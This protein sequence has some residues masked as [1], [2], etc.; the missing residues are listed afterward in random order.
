MSR[1]RRRR[2]RRSVAALAATLVVSTGAGGCTDDAATGPEPG[3]DVTAC[4]VEPDVPFVYLGRDG[5]PT[6]FSFELLRAIVRLRRGTLRLDRVSASRVEFRL[7]DGRCDVIVSSMT[8]DPAREQTLRF[9]PPYLDADLALGVRGTDAA[10]FPTVASLTTHRIGVVAGSDGEA[11]LSANLPPGS[12]AVAFPVAADAFAALRAEDVDGV[13]A[14]RAVVAHRALADTA[15][16]ATEVVPTGR[17][18][19]FGLRPRDAASL[20][21]VTTGLERLHDDGS[22]AELR[23][24]WFGDQLDG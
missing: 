4:A 13:L 22:Y 19:V 15:I 10:L 12:V 8:D 7:L 5:A 16:R 17:S 1:S 2:P 21:L 23:Q 14:R 24:R 11:W 20:R 3:P 18:L 6:G 9:S